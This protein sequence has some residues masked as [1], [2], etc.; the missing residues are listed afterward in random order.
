MR[1]LIFNLFIAFAA[2]FFTAVT[3]PAFAG[4]AG[5]SW[6]DD[7]GFGGNGGF[8]GGG[9]G[10]SWAGVCTAN[11][12]T[13]KFTGSSVGSI[14]SQFNDSIPHATMFE[15]RD[16]KTCRAGMNGSWY[17]S[18]TPSCK[19]DLPSCPA[20]QVRD[21][22]GNCVP[23]LKCPAGYVKSGDSCI[24]QCPAGFK[25]LGGN[26]VKDD[27]PEDCDPAIQEC[28][29]DGTPK[30]DPCSKLQQLINNNLTMINN[31]NRVISLTENIVTTMNTTNNNIN[32]VNT[33]INNVNNNISNV[34]TSINN[35]NNNISNVNN[36]LTTINESIQNVITSIENNKP[37]F[38]TSSIVSKLDEVINAIRNNNGVGEDGQPIDLTEIIRLLNEIDTGV[39]DGKFDDTQLNAYFDE[40]IEK[41][42]PV[43]V[44]FTPVTERQ[45]EQTGLLE[46]IKRLLM[47]TNEAG[48]PSLDLPEVD[49]FDAH[50]DPWSAIRGFD[51]NQNMINAQAQ[52][53]SGDAYSFTFLGKT[54]AMPMQILCGYLGQIGVG[55]MFLAYISGA[56][57]IVK[58]D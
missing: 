45:D 27:Q 41:G 7:S 57:I 40:I 6:G 39:K 52:C 38:D 33:S 17:W 22:S 50:L 14:C 19:D 43:G 35:V 44:D 2:M 56:F 53:P 30:C 31:D 48:D 26:C 37:D 11:Y 51:V 32:N 21:P 3:M 54:F 4:G 1:N 29:E 8:G 24:W 25:M 28:N 10:G 58:G 18:V 42:I 16:G 5:G 9:A 55:I 34:N 13:N 12:G 36:N 23:E 46:D 49:E 47:P 20:G 15:I